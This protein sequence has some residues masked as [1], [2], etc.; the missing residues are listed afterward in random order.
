MPTATLTLSREIPLVYHSEGFHQFLNYL[1]LV[2]Q[3]QPVPAVVGQPYQNMVSTFAWQ[4]ASQV[5]AAVP[6]RCSLITPPSSRN[7]SQP[8]VD[9]ILLDRPLLNLSAQ[10]SRKYGVR[11]ATATS[12][13]QLID[14]FEYRPSGKEPSI[15]SLLIVDETIAS[16]R[17]VHAVL[18][19]LLREGLPIDCEVTAVTALLVR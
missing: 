9:A 13:Q 6:N 1:N 3:G 16:G 4:L 8:Y 14:E 5:V 18:H 17:T 12:L 11:A 15:K 19:H 2:R 10:M 7:D